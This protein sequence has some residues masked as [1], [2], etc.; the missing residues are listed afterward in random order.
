METVDELLIEKTLAGSL[1]CFDVLMQRYQRDVFAVARGYAK[2]SDDALDICQNA[3]LK[4]YSKLETFAGRS[5]FRTWLTSIANREGLNWV[6]TKSRKA[7]ATQSDTQLESLP[8][9]DD[10][11]TDLLQAER[12]QLIIDSLHIL[13]P[14]SR[15]AVILR[16]F[17]EMPISEVAVVLDC[18]E[19]VAR[20]M[21]FRS[22]RK[23]REAVAPQ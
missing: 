15:M 21:L 14:R 7:P 16:Y 13:N 18:S 23:L 12:R 1:E 17:R 5:S 2:S 10:H 11:E 6:R 8:A 22:V 3:F 9:G 4:A 19:G 20:N